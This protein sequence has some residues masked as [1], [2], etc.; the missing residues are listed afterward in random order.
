MR[1]PGPLSPATAA[2]ASLPLVALLLAGALLACDPGARTADPSA[3][4]ERVEAGFGMGAPALFAAPAQQAEQRSSARGRSERESTLQQLR[5][6]PPG[7]PPH[8]A[9]GGGF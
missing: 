3:A 6:G 8:A 4:G 2:A 1:L 5:T 9:V 7:G